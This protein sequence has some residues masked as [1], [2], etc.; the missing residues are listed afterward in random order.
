MIPDLADFFLRFLCERGGGK[1]EKK[2]EEKGVPQM[3]TGGN[4]H[5]G[6]S[7][8]YSYSCGRNRAGGKKKRGGGEG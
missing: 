7:N 2:K 8:F 5:F 6:I 3:K 4:A 1:I